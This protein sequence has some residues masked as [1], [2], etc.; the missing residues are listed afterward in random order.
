LWGPFGAYAFYGTIL[1]L[2]IVIVYILINLA[3][4]AFYRRDYPVEFSVLRHGVLPVIGSVLMLLPIYGLLWPVPA[5]PNNLVPY[6]VA[7]WVVLGGIYLA[8]ISSRRPE[9][10]D[11]M[12]RAMGEEAPAQA[13][14]GRA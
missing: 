12:G 4:V 2:G 7:T 11:A 13:Q 9:V 10:L 1:G 6:I 8:V 5:Y 3:L 14:R